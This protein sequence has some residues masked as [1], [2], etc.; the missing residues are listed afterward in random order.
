MGWEAICEA[1]GQDPVVLFLNSEPSV[2]GIRGYNVFGQSDSVWRHFGGGL[3]RRE[4]EHPSATWWLQFA[5]FPQG[6]AISASL[7]RR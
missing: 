6:I 2:S 3:G 1:K 5:I 4:T 7:F